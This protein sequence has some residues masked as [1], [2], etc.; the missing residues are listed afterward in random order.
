MLLFKILPNS[1]SLYA[2]TA[3]DLMQHSSGPRT[4]HL[5]PDFSTSDVYAETV[6]QLYSQ[7]FQSAG[8]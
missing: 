6:S 2:Y 5:F 4:T 1:S 7:S 8:S 3:P